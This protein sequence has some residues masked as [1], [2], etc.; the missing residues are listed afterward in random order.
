[1]RKT[2]FLL[3]LIFTVSSPLAFAHPDLESVSINDSDGPI[4]GIK[5]T[6]LEK[7]YTVKTEI[8][9]LSDQWV[10]QNFLWMLLGTISI[11]MGIFGLIL[12]RDERPSLKIKT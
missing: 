2:V 10:V 8:E 7:T 3:I 5:I 9:F 1:M 6:G 11:F 4:P 12:Y